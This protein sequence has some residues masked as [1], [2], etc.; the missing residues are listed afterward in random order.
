[1]KFVKANNFLA[2]LRGLMLL[3]TGGYVLI[4]ITFPALI[5][6]ITTIIENPDGGGRFLWGLITSLYTHYSVAAT[7]TTVYSV[8]VFGNIKRIRRSSGRG[9]IAF[10]VL[11]NVSAIVLAVCIFNSY[12]E[13]ESEP[14]L[15][16]YLMIAAL[17]ILAVIGFIFDIIGIKA[18]CYMRGESAF[19]DSV[20]KTVRM[21]NVCASIGLCAGIIPAFYLT[22]F[23][24][25]LRY[26][27]DKTNLE[28]AEI[29]LLAASVI[30]AF[31]LAVAAI[32][33]R[34]GRGNFLAVVLAM[35]A[36]AMGMSVAFALADAEGVGYVYM[37]AICVGSLMLILGA[38]FI[39]ADNARHK[40]EEQEY[41]MRLRERART[42]CI[43]AK[44]AYGYR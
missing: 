21:K 17:I 8:F 4:K 34:K 27:I 32:A 16:A 11:G 10:D 24:T 35:S 2:V 14:D 44:R 26:A 1:M 43:R 22:L 25:L 38:V 12:S 7:V 31:V 29:V 28:I 20:P 23:L 6:M 15:Y 40:R 30:A 13:I 9:F 18:V 33:S 42:D 41:M 5:S 36:L 19:K 3:V 39:I 37:V